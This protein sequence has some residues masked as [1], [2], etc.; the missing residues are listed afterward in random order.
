MNLSDEAEAKNADIIDLHAKSPTKLCAEAILH[1]RRH[2]VKPPPNE[3]E[4][5]ELQSRHKQSF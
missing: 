2:T 1:D 4:P 3:I 5:E